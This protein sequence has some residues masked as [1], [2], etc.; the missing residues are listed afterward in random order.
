MAD[1]LAAAGQGNI[2]EEE[3]GEWLNEDDD[4]PGYPRQAEEEIAEDMQRSGTPAEEEEEEVEAPGPSLAP[5]IDATDT[6]LNLIDRVGG[7]LAKHYEVI[8]NMRLE[9]MQMQ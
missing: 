1:L 2:A 8:H 6:V 3:L 7:C 4:L 5:G 9:M